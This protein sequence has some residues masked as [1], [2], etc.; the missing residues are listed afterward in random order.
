MRYLLPLALSCAMLAGCAQFD[1]QI[2]QPP[3]LSQRIT[4]QPA[5]LTT[6]N[7]NYQMRA[8]EG[9]LVIGISNPGAQTLRLLGD[10]SY[11]VDPS[12]YSHPLMPRT[13][14][15]GAY[16]RIALPPLRPYYRSYA[17][18]WGYFGY[19]PPYYP[20]YSPYYYGYYPAPYYDAFPNGYAYGGYDQN[21]DHYWD[22]NGQSEVRVSL[23]YQREDNT[24][25]RDEFTIQKMKR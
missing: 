10:R 25:F 1:F 4:K 16:A 21:N 14:G 20:Y 18:R 24:T 19:G 15:P 7:V 13:I 23:V 17:A 12:G 8:S 9:R 3:A 5:Q 2:T 22:W 11:V 6:G